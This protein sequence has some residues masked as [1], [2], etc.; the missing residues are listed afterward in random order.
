ME[1]R[2]FIDWIAATIHQP[3]R[4]QADCPEWG[5]AITALPAKEWIESKARHGYKWAASHAAGFEVMGSPSEMGVHVICPGHALQ[6]SKFA[7]INAQGILSAVNRYK[8]KLARLDLAIDAVETGL[9]IDDL[10]DMMLDGTAYTTSKTWN[11]VI[12]PN[13]GQTLYIGARSSERFIRIYNKTAQLAASAGVPDA[14]DWKRIELEAKATAARAFGSLLL[15]GSP[16]D[17]VACEAI[18][19]VVDFPGDRI[20]QGIFNEPGRAVAHSHRTLHNSERWLLG[21]VAHSLARQLKRDPQF[22]ERF[23][24]AVRSFFDAET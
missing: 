14:A 19:A 23:E 3:A 6:G 17:R 9:S 11:F 5:E 24:R 8:G 21:T 20:W 7:S 10:A 1:T 13:G 4:G 2:A 15:A 16:V 12:A 18:T 22:K